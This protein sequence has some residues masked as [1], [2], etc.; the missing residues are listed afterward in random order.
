M[1]HTSLFCASFYS[2]HEKEEENTCP[3]V[4]KRTDKVTLFE[5]RQTKK[6]LMLPKQ[7]TQIDKPLLPGWSSSSWL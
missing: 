7:N 5:M 4:P 1:L 3:Q 6:S 2:F